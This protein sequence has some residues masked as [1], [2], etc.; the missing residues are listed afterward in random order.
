MYEASGSRDENPEGVMIRSEMTAM[1]VGVSF[2]RS[3]IRVLYTS[4]YNSNTLSVDG[5]NVELTI[6]SRQCSVLICP[7]RTGSTYYHLYPTEA[8]SNE[9]L[10][11]HRRLVSYTRNSQ[12]CFWEQ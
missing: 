10:S 2:V 8:K 9:T 4:D 6:G 7:L 3:L 1:F 11:A 12:P 5:V